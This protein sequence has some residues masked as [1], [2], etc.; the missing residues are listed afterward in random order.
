MRFIWYRNKELSR[1]NIGQKEIRMRHHVIG[2][3]SLHTG[4]IAG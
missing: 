2:D 3:A 4:M 1:N